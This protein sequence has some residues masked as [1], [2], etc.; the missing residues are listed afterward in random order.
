MANDRS[1]LKNLAAQEPERL[2]T[3]VKEW[4]R[5]AADVRQAPAE[6]CKPVATEAKP[7]ANREWSDHSKGPTAPGPRRGANNKREN[8]K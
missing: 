8:K 6:H 5:M 4:H 2:K 1:E 7:W 3:M